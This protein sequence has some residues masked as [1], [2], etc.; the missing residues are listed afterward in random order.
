MGLIFA[1]TWQAKQLH[2]LVFVSNQT[3]IYSASEEV[4]FPLIS[5]EKEKEQ[6]QSIFLLV[7]FILPDLSL[8]VR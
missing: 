4:V 7:P 1:I 2:R 3:K 8:L 5:L 6:C